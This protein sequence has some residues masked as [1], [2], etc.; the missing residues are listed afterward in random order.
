MRAIEKT[1]K[2]REE[3]ILAMSQIFSKWELMDRLG[4]RMNT[5]YDRLI[6]HCQEVCS[7]K[8]GN[9]REKRNE[10]HNTE[11]HVLRQ[12]VVEACL[13]DN[14]HFDKSYLNALIRRLVKNENMLAAMAEQHKAEV[15][16]LKQRISHLE[17]QLEFRQKYKEKKAIKI[18]AAI[19]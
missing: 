10:E 9:V 13:D 7:M 12:A 5:T 14:P 1:Y 16:R 4:I 17:Q 6:K 3:E 19:Q 8:R 2:G 15:L 11:L 18:L